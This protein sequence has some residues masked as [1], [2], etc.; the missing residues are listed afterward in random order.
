MEHIICINQNSFPANNIPDGKKFFEDALQGILQ[1][2]NGSDRFLFYLDCNNGGLYDFILS[3]NYTYE[4]FIDDC[5]DN[6]LA[7]FLSEVEDKSPALDNL[8]K[9]QI[10]E[11]SA[12]NFYVPNQ[13]IDNHPDV[14]ALCWAVSGYLLSIQSHE[15][16]SE[17]DI[18][19]ARADEQ[20]RY[21]QETLSIKNISTISHG[22]I[23]Y[24]AIYDVD[25]E[26]IL[27]P[28]TISQTLISWF[29]IQTPENRLRITDKL[30]LACS[31]QFQGSEPLFKSL[32]NSNGLREIRIPAYSGGAIRILFKNIQ[33]QCQALL[34]GFIKHSDNE[35]YD[36]AMKQANILFDNLKNH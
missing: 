24:Q 18:I 12:Y 23:H 22:N 10:D 29:N 32:K 11:M 31:R 17:S 1:L 25:L 27:S 13:G 2:Q 34:V 15:R 21:I 9:E 8:T 26:T 4:Q 5:E 35:G 30:K 36:V 7:L 28:H 16:W 6:D 14:Y 19:I 3:K 20:G 33:H